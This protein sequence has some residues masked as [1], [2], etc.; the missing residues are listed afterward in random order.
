MNASAY[1]LSEYLGVTR[2]TGEENY[3]AQIKVNKRTLYLG[4]FKNPK[5]AARERDKASRQFF[6]EFANL[7]FKDNI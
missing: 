4:C 3:F 7:N 6:G 5:D 1:G 2:R